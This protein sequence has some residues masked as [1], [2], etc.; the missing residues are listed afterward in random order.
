MDFGILLQAIGCVAGYLFL[1]GLLLSLLLGWITFVVEMTQDRFL[2]G[3]IILLP[4]VVVLIILV[5]HK[6]AGL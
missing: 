1:I 5:Y 4:I 2:Q 6:I 3:I